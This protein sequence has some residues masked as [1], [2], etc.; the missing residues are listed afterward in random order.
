MAPFNRSHEFLSS[1]ILT[2]AVSCTVFEIKRDFGRKC[3]FYRATRLHSADYMLWQDVRLSV[4]LSVT[5]WYS[6]K[7]GKHI[8]KLFSPSGRH[9]IVFPNQTV[10]Q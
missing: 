5:R 1:S 7:T 9:T 6:V 4:R 2:M 10:S 8:I 3:E